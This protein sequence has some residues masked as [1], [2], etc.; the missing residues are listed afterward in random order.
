MG[1][2]WFFGVE[3][4]RRPS[5]PGRPRLVPAGGGRGVPRWKAG[6]ATTSSRANSVPRIAA[7]EL[8]ERLSAGGDVLVL[9]LRSDAAFEASG[10]MVLGALRIRPAVIHREAPSCRATRGDPL[11]L[12]TERSHQRQSGADPDQEGHRNVSILRGGLDDWIREGLPTQPVG[13]AS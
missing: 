13:Q 1:L 7:R 5:A 11:L 6:Y 10:A 12:L 9:D 8:H 4:S 3:I 2:G